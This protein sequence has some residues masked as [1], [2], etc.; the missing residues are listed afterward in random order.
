MATDDHKWCSEYLG[1]ARPYQD[2]VRDADVRLVESFSYDDGRGR[3]YRFSDLD[4]HCLVWFT[5]KALDVPIGQT[6]RASFVIKSH[7]DFNGVRENITKNFRIL[8]IHK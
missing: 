2:G 7:R 8:A 5:K 4:G 1:S 6:Y 3:C